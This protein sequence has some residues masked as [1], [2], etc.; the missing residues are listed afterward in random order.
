MDEHAFSDLP[1]KFWDYLGE[2]RFPMWLMRM[3]ESW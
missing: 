3:T 1:P 2:Q